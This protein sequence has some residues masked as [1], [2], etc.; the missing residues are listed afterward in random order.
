M[1]SSR[2]LLMIYAI[3]GALLVIGFILILS[4]LMMIFASMIGEIF[5]YGQ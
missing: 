3:S 4:M 2:K 1:K 5:H